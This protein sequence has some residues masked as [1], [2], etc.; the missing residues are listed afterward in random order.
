MDSQ[1][2]LTAPNSRYIKAHKSRSIFSLLRS[3]NCHLFFIKND[4][5]PNYDDQFQW[6]LFS[7]IRFSLRFNAIIPIGSKMN[8]FIWFCYANI[9][10]V[11]WKKEQIKISYIL[12]F[13]TLS[14]T[15]LVFLF[16]SNRP[17]EF[18]PRLFG[19]SSCDEIHLFLLS[20]YNWK[21]KPN[22]QFDSI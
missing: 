6:S 2:C 18:R 8:G 5:S 14:W 20:K 13:D 1:L 10:L 19:C 12:W 21:W 11:L 3:K 17:V 9:D 15:N 22:L 7:R 4:F 16:A